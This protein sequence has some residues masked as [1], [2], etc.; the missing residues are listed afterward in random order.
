MI[1]RKQWE[2]DRLRVDFMV[3]G[4]SYEHISAKLPAGRRYRST[5]T[6]DGDRV[7]CS[8]AEIQAEC[9]AS[10]ANVRG[11]EEARERDWLKFKEGCEMMAALGRAFAEQVDRDLAAILKGTS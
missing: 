5:V 7:V 10:W 2:A 11:T 4:L 9:D 6:L 3:F 8:E 1:T